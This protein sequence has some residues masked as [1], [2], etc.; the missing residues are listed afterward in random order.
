MQ[1]RS[2]LSGKDLVIQVGRQ[3][4]AVLFLLHESC[5]DRNTP[6]TA[7]AGRI[8]NSNR[9]IHACCHDALSHH[10]GLEEAAVSHQGIHSHMLLFQQNIHTDL[11]GSHR[12]VQ[13]GTHE[14]R[15]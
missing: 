2:G 10:G 9:C 3:G 14:I 1:S 6:G 8:H 7:F 15:Q 5:Q 12:A 11:Q 13:M 4:L